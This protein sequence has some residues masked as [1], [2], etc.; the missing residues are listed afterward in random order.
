[1]K[2]LCEWKQKTI[3]RCVIVISQVLINRRNM[4]ERKISGTWMEKKKISR[5]RRGIVGNVHNKGL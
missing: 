1:M 3:K 5:E 2:S 4:D